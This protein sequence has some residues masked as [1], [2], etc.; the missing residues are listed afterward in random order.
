MEIIPSLLLRSPRGSRR[1]RMHDSYVSDGALRIPPGA[2]I[3]A[4]SLSMYK[5][6][7]RSWEMR[8]TAPGRQ[9]IH[10]FQPDDAIPPTE[11]GV[12]ILRPRASQ[13]KRTSACPRPLVIMSPAILYESVSAPA[14]ITNLGGCVQPRG[15]LGRNGD[16]ASALQ[17][18]SII[19]G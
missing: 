2:R 4:G 14:H 16:G 1:S 19:R 7:Q 11:F 9:E 13:T 12:R 5:L 3:V 15:I 8:E 18:N 6:N 17:R 10:H